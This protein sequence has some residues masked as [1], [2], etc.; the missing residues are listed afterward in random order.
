[1]NRKYLAS[2]KALERNYPHLQTPIETTTNPE[3][4]R[5]FSQ[6]LKPE[7]SIP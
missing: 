3:P 2:S 5:I 1:M 4:Y 7:T 6:N